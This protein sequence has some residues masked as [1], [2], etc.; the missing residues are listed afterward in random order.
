M[1][2]SV[3]LKALRQIQE[4]DEFGGAFREPGELVKVYDH[5]VAQKISAGDAEPLDDG[6]ATLPVK[7]PD[8]QGA[9]SLPSLDGDGEAA[10]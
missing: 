8:F 2:N 9:H 6:E 3:T 1:S 7:P 4:P 5:E 10:G